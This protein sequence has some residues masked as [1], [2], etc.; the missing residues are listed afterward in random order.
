M[1]C[2]LSGIIRQNKTQNRGVLSLAN[3][4]HWF[5]R[6]QKANF[7]Q[8]MCYFMEVAQIGQSMSQKLK[9]V[10]DEVCK[11]AWVDSGCPLLCW[12]NGTVWGVPVADASKAPCQL[13]STL[14]VLLLLLLQ[15]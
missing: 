13:E 7:H 4:K 2:D 12:S 10:G 1:L 8:R 5:L 6:I 9:A 3:F 14:V 15:L 11:S